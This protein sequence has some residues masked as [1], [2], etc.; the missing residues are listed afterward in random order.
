[1][2]KI[3]F[4]IGTLLFSSNINQDQLPG[5]SKIVEANTGAKPPLAR[6][7]ARG[8]AAGLGNP[9]PLSLDCVSPVR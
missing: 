8:G 4:S 6:K 5:S 3:K 2:D 7:T 1:M 9:A